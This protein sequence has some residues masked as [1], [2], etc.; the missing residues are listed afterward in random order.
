MPAICPCVL[1]ERVDRV[2]DAEAEK[3]GLWSRSSGTPGPA[4]RRLDRGRL[5]AMRLVDESVLSAR[6]TPLETT[7]P[8]VVVAGN[9]AT[10]H[11][12][13]GCVDKALPTYRLF[14]LNAQAG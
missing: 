5:H 13:L 2:R 8:R 12:L 9:F 11:A 4:R 14:A 10:P 1:Q 3:Q 6:L 7:H